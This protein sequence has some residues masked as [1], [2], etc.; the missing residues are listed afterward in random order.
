[1]LAVCFRYVGEKMEAE[2]ILQEAFLKIFTHFSKYD[3]NGS[4]GGWIRTVVVH[5]AI[6][7]YRK[8][9]R[10]LI[11]FS[12][13]GLPRMGFDEGTV[14]RMEARQILLLVSELP[15]GYR[16]VF[17][18]YAVEG[19]KHH[20]IATMLGISEGT[21]K[22]Q[23][24]RARKFLQDLIYKKLKIDVTHAARGI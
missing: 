7:H 20:E 18:L 11:D 24:A 4:L 15:D 2:D 1:M 3:G 14:D 6:E 5:T 19:F 23:Y 13:E 16:Q 21:S 8:N 10:S 12:D 17:N 22:S 9:K